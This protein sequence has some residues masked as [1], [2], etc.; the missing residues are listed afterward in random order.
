LASLQ[1]KVRSDILAEKHLEEACSS[2]DK[3]IFDWSLM[4]LVRTSASFFGSLHGDG[5]ISGLSPGEADERLRRKR[6]AEV[7]YS[8]LKKKGCHVNGQ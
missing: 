8:S 2:V 1:K 5:F 3:C 6:E 7:K 4:R